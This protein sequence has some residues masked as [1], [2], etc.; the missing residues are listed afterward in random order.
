MFEI[1][2]QD[3]NFVAVDKPAGWLTVPSR[4]E[5]EDPRRVLGRELEK[6]LNVRLFPV[7]RLDFEVSG[8]VLFAKNANAHRDAGRWFEQRLVKKTYQ[9]LSNRRDFAHWPA[10]LPKADEEI[11]PGVELE[12]RCKLLRGKRR[13]YE[14]AKGDASVT[15]ALLNNSLTTES[16]QWILNPHT[17]RPHQLRFELS[18]HGFPI[19]GDELYGSKKSWQDGAIALRAVRLDF[20]GV[21]NLE[22]WNLPTELHVKGLFE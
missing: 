1:V 15:F 2:W 8:L 14:H 10:N 20:S 11:K 12:W 17:G 13:S 3:D 9:A 18:R 4:Y 22:K 7:H 21:N 5:D 6:S 19:L 16:L